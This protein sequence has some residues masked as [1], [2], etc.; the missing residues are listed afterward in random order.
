M[1]VLVWVLE[2]REESKRT[3]EELLTWAVFRISNIENGLEKD[4]S[5]SKQKNFSPPVDPIS[6]H[7]KAA[8]DIFP[9]SPVLR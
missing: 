8:H 7:M 2:P 6:L 1:I 3:T 4:N 9:P 5:N